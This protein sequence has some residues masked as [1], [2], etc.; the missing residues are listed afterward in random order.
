MATGAQVSTA[1]PALCAPSAS[2]FGLLP[3]PPDAPPP[4]PGMET[5]VV[6]PDAHFDYGGYG[7]ASMPQ[8]QESD[9][10]SY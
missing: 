5:F 8:H 3:Y 1:D 9:Q 4:A 10:C 2:Y 6:G 7:Q